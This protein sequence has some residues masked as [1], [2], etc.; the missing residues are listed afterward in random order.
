MW[1][2]AFFH[3]QSSVC[4]S[5]VATKGPEKWFAFSAEIVPGQG[6]LSLKLTCKQLES[7]PRDSPP[8]LLNPHPWIPFTALINIHKA[9]H[10]ECLVPLNG[11]LFLMETYISRIISAFSCKLGVLI[12]QSGQSMNTSIM[13]WRNTWCFG[14]RG[15]SELT[16]CQCQG[17]PGSHHYHSDSSPWYCRFGSMCNFM[18]LSCKCHRECTKIPAV[19]FILHCLQLNF[20]IW[21]FFF[22]FKY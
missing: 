22:Y 1:Q 8:Q 12:L 6:L 16:W 3:Q 19:L 4:S 21:R 14:L 15:G 5:G 7:L 9:P 17:F 13:N 2:L 11:L 10:K 20:I 18:L